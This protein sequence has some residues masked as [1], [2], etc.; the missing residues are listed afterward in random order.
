MV[1]KILKVVKTVITVFLVVILG[2]I[3]VQR[4]SNNN[5]AVG[6]F[7]IF[8]VISE[9]ME[10]AYQIGDILVSKKTEPQN[11]NVGDRV[12]YKGAEESIRGLIIT[13]EVIERREESGKF[14]FVTQGLANDVADP[15]ISQDD[16][17]GKVI[18]RTMIFSFFGRIMTNDIVY[19]VLFILVGG[20]ASYQVVSG[21]LKKEDK[22]EYVEIP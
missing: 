6:G 4:F 20:A 13:H 9:S 5:L 12:T 2:V 21:F 8:T 15:E 18:Y 3:L 14:F 10:P 17:Y 1:K 7:R 11:I 22:Y 16:I 19:Y